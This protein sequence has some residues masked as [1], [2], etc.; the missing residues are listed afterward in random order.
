METID[1]FVSQWF[2]F[3]ELQFSGHWLETAG[4]AVLVSLAQWQCLLPVEP[5][6]IL[7]VPCTLCNF[8]YEERQDKDTFWY[9]W[10]LRP[11]LK[12]QNIK[13]ILEPFLFLSRA[14]K[15]FFKRSRKI[16]LQDILCTSVLHHELQRVTELRRIENAIPKAG[17]QCVQKGVRLLWGYMYSLF[18]GTVLVLE[19]SIQVVFFFFL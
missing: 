5:G 15:A 17:E 13:K 9:F 14:Y 16:R 4:P 19:L 6:P 7:G 11:P 10:S 8:L 3:V 2:L 1:M 12:Y 18:W